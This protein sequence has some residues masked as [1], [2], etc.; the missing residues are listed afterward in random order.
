MAHAHGQGVQ[1][2][3]QALLQVA[4][5][6]ERGFLCG[7]VIGGLRDRHQPAQAQVGQA[8][9]R[10]GQ[11]REVGGCA[12]GLAVFATDIHLQADVQRRQ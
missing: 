11:R 5:A 1:A 3:A 8:G 9:D 6:G 12:A 2:K 7:A 4:Q 10:L